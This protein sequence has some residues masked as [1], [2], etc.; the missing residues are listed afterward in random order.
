MVQER[1]LEAQLRA[2]M[3]NAHPQEAVA[4][5]L[6]WWRERFQEANQRA[7]T[8]KEEEDTQRLLYALAEAIA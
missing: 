5:T 6:T 2:E 1:V 8:E 4:N 3:A 7:P